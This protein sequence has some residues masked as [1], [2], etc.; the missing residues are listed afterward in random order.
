MK[1]DSLYNKV[2]LTEQNDEISLPDDVDA[3][4]NA[5]GEIADTGAE[6]PE[7]ENFETEPA[8]VDGPT[9]DIGALKN[10]IST[11]E[12]LIT[13]LNG[14]EA[15]SLQK[16]VNDLDRPNSLYTGIAGDTSPEITKLAEQTAS[17]VEILKG[18]IIIS[19]KRQR[20]LLSTNA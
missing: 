13:S 9:G 4:I 19:A 10:Y 18:Y 15:D 8:P 14:V 12:E 6:V 1:F 7:P 2:F 5:D 11:L 3:D 17:L 16:L 20:D